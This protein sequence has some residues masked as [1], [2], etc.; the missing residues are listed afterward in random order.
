MRT[1]LGC[2][3]YLSADLIGDITVLICWALGFFKEEILPHYDDDP[4]NR[5]TSKSMKD[6]WKKSDFHC[7][8]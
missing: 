1:L 5:I 4:R 8:Q 6:G 3:L 7:L 2:G